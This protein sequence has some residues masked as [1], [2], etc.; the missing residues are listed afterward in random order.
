VFLAALVLFCTI[1][2]TVN[3]R[4]TTPFLKTIRGFAFAGKNF[5]QVAP[6]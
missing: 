3:D 5:M 6:Y 1:A 4:G 2:V